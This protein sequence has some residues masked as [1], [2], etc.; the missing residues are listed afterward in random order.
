MKTVQKEVVF[1][2]HGKPLSAHNDKV[3]AAGYAKWVKDYDKSELDPASL[4]REKAN[5][6]ES[7]VIVSP[8]LRAR[9]SAKQYGVLHTDE[10]CQNLKEMD[11]PFYNIPLKLK[12]WHWVLLS[13]TL[14]FAGLKG[15]F[16]SFI[17]AKKRTVNLAQHIQTLSEE[18][19][20]IVLF[21]HGMTNYFTRKQLVKNGW[22]LQ[23]KSGDF[24]GITTL[25]KS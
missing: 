4:P 7:Y 16:E 25:T 19:N 3:N 11:I 17:Q 2:R 20:R 10:T 8:L 6:E 18:H 14:W 22:H 21:G 12:A 15:D 13:R 1:I 24:W 9:L 23:N 5:L